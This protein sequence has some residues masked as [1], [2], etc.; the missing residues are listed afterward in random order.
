MIYT[1]TANPS[2]DY[3]MKVRKHNVGGT[4]RSIK[5][6]IVAGGKGLNVSL[7]LNNFGMQTKALAITAGFTGKR[8]LELV[9]EAGV[10]VQT[11]ML[12]NGETRINVK[13]VGHE[14]VE[15]N[16]SG[17]IVPV[18]RHA[19]IHDMFEQISG[20]DTLVISGKGTPGM[21]PDSYAMIMDHLRDRGTRIIVDSSGDFMRPAIEC[22]P[23]FIK[24]NFDELKDIGNTYIA[25]E[26]DAICCCERL[27]RMGAQNVL[28]SLGKD[29]AIWVGGDGQKYKAKVPKGRIKSTVGSG[30][31]MVAAFLYGLENNEPL[32]MCL[33][34]AAAAGTAGAFSE[35][36]VTKDEVY[37]ILDK[38]EI[39]QI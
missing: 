22:N 20:D 30:D 3:I 36:L 24:P 33:K 27:I 34:L 31:S 32:E 4:D 37:G 17:P 39:S 7:V 14:E 2:L 29:G 21:K 13:L 35:K 15:I 8:W 18:S 5:E 16:A 1:F 23:Y 10:D 12:D 26:D 25:S 9:D 11:V 19:E 6:W 38:I 28:L